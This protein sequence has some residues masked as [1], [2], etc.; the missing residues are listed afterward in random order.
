MDID[1]FVEF[2]DNPEPNVAEINLWNPSK[3]TI[4]SVKKGTRVVL[5]AG[6]VGDIGVLIAGTVGDYE[7]VY[8]VVDR[9][10]KMYVGD[11]VDVWN[12]R[13]KKTY[14]D[15]NADAVC[16]DLLGL[17]G[18]SAKV[19]LAKNVTFPQ[20]VFDCSIQDAIKRVAKATDSKFYIKNKQ[21]FVVKKDFAEKSMFLLNKDSGLIGTP[22][23]ILIDE[24]VGY[25][26]N[27][28]L[29]HRINVGSYVRLQSKS[30]NGDF[31]V[32]KGKHSE[33][34]EMEV[35]PK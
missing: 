11:G 23:K 20:L 3:E 5:N 19:E 16:K 10:L 9:M 27:C 33:I 22:E 30:V 31:R 4:A 21:G 6:F 7:V 17:V 12:T 35:L 2:D 8:S 1:F 24:K 29:E 18:L 32:I 28:L 34:T 14:K 13:I 15:A 26:V 25:R